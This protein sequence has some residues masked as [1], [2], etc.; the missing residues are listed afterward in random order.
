MNKKAEEEIEE[1]KHLKIFEIHVAIFF[2]TN[3]FDSND[4]DS[5]SDWPGV[6]PV[7]PAVLVDPH[8]DG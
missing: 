7:A 5:W 4:E 2:A 6:D 8:S 3:P 1:K